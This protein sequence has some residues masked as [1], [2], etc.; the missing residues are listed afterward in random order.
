M[1]SNNQ[2]LT[3]L[4]LKKNINPIN[5]SINKSVHKK[6]SL[7]NR[8]LSHDVSIITVTNR[9]SNIDNI[10]DNYSRQ[11]NIKKELIIILNNN[12]CDINK[13]RDSF[14]NLSNVSIFQLDE[15]KSLGKCLNFGIEKSKYNIIAKFDDDDYYANKYLSDSV[16]EFKKRNV[17]VVGKA[18]YFVYFKKSKT[19]ALRMPQNENKMVN[20]V[21]GSTL[22]FKKEIYNKIK[23]ADLTLG[24]D[25]QFCKDCLKNKINIFSSS[26]YNHVVIRSDATAHHTYKLSDEEFIKCCIFIAKTN[27]FMSY[28]LKH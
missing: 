20:F 10:F 28:I 14:K 15:K 3:K 19:L 9:P 13:Y 5:K 6:T 23:F 12:K 2:I 26:K 18:A 11:T 7:K 17:K 27:D 4:K 1:A 21:N 16:K 22:I 8:S 24:E 25:V